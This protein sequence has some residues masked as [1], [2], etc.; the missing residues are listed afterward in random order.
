MAFGTTTSAYEMDGVGA[1]NS[2]ADQIAGLKGIAQSNSAFNA[3]QAKI[4]REWSEAQSAKAMEFNSNEAAKNR[5]WQEMMSNTAHQ[6][7]V[8]DLLRNVCGYAS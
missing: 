5:N 2:A 6:R 3:E 1:V 7:E 8:K 4:Q